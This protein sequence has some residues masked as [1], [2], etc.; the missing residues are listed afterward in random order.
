MRWRIHG[1]LVL[2][3]GVALVNATGCQSASY[4]ERGTMLGA[5]GGAGVGALIGRATGHTGAG[6]LIGTGV[7]A[8]TGAA[9]GTALDDIEARNRAEIAARMGRPVAPGAAT[10]AEVLSMTQAGVDQRLI[11]NYV[12]N[13]GVAQP[14]TAQDV[15]YLHQQGVHPDVL[16]AMQNPRA[17]QRP[18][19]IVQVPPPRETVIIYQDPWHSHC[20]PRY[21]FSYGF[22]SHCH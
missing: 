22:G 1:V 3:T 9:V 16:Q 2:F 17:A 7:G 14:L 4:G 13:S 18:A 8:M 20:Y 5:L 10:T 15:I 19:Q 11:V 6:A 21:H 12:N